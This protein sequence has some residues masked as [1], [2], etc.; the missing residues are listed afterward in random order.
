MNTVPTVNDE[1]GDTMWN[2]VLTEAEQW[3]TGPDAALDI[4]FRY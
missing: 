2:R 1:C 3:Y 4:W